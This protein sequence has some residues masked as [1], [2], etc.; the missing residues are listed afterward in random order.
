MN[1]FIYENSTKTYFGKGC[2]KEYLT[3]LIRHYGKKVMFAYGG[4]SITGNGIYDEIMESLAKAEKNVIEFS[5]ICENPTY[6]KVLEG[7]KLAKENEIDFILAVGG[8]SVMDCCK[9]VSMAAV[10]DGD[11]WND[12][13]ARHGFMEFDPVPLGA[14]VT[15]TE[16]GSEMNGRAVITNEALKIRTG[17]D[18]SKCNPRFAL[19]DP[20]YSYC[21]PQRQMVS[22]GFDTLSHIMEIYF[23]KPD[24]DNVSDDMAEALMKNVIQNLRAAIV[25]PKDYTARSN[26]IW[27]AAMADNGILKL[28]KQADF[29][30]QQMEYQLAA[31]TNCNQGEGL[32]VLHPVY[33]RHIYRNGSRKFRRFAVNVWGISDSGKTEEETA[34]EGVEALADFIKEVGLPVSLR[35]L[36]AD[37]NTDLKQIA[38]SCILSGGSYKQ[39]THREI[40]EIFQECY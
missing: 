6:E 39:M 40:H 7:A 8:G 15:E 21:V 3:C 1:N 34:H 33:C 38:D 2:V 13:F 29:Q 9:A 19:I 30:C 32:A 36:G 17:R 28:G 37:E 12:F 22:D 24:E 5:G 16:T 23:S 10:Y 35:D 27:D 25:N 26:L 14:V 18:Y 4:D 20:A 11:V 31:Y